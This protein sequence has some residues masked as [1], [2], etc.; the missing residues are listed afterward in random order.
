MEINFKAHL[1]DTTQVMKRGRFCKKY[2]PQNVS[3]VK[4]D[5]DSKHDKKTLK[6]LK[7]LWYC[8]FAG[9]I[10]YDATKTNKPISVYAITT[11]TDC[12]EK[13]KP[14]E[15]LGIAETTETYKKANLE[16]IQIHPEYTYN[17]TDSKRKFTGV[18]T[19]LLDM[20]KGLK[21]LQQI[22]VTS[23]FQTIPFYEKN[24]FTI[25]NMD[26]EGTLIWK[27]DKY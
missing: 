14:K 22:K 23:V 18:G 16:Y 1:I 26:D 13:L 6:K 24:G 3:F 10:F 4:L 21:N 12:F 2:E 11:Q 19:A 7:N 27:K 17:E 25:S 15:I 9:Q 8:T 20:I 5:L